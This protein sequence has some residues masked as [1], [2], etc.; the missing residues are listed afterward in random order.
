MKSALGAA[1][2]LTLQALPRRLLLMR[3]AQSLLLA[4]SS[5]A[6]VAQASDMDTYA[7]AL[8]SDNASAMVDLIFKG[9]N[10]NTLD[11]KGRPGLVAALQQDSFR[12]YEVLLKSPGINVN[13]ASAQGET[14]LMMACI[15]GE[16]KKVKTLIERGADI[17]REGWTPLHYAVSTDKPETLEIIKLLLEGSAYI[18]AS[19]PNGS[20]PLMLAAQYS[21]EGVVDLLIKEGA[22]VV[23]RNQRGLTAVDFAQK[24]E[25]PYIV[26]RLNKAV[27]TERRTLPSRGSW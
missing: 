9:F 27:Q 8:V 26:E 22:D 12:V 17:N 18:D 15:K 16:L 10:P 3:G 11:A 20:T 6:G 23:V 2:P 19:S 21:S 5:V 7:R 25:R 24:A 4:A 1:V 14:P 13:L